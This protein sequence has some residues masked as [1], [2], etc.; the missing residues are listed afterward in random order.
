MPTNWTMLTHKQI[1]VVFAS[2]QQQLD[3]VVED[4]IGPCPSS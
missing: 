3:V 4:Q 1:W 2:H